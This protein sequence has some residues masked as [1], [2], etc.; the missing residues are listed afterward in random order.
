MNHFIKLSGRVINKIHIV[1]IVQYPNHYSI[2]MSNN[3][4]NGFM[5]FSVGQIS[6][7]FN[8]IDVCEKKN[9]QDYDTITKFITEIK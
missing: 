2:I 4:G 1:E 6:S 9:K 8:M 3:G 5:F 7:N